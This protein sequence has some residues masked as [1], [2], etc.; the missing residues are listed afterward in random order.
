[1]TIA[2]HGSKYSSCK[3]FLKY[4][5]ADIYTISAGKNN[6]Y[7]HPHKE[8]LERLDEY[9]PSAKVLRTDECGQI[10]VSVKKN[11]TCISIFNSNIPK[12][13]N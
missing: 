12:Q 7:G 5:N 8:T 4:V 13:K 11:E 2:H 1:M 9:A 10:T 6:S 3:E